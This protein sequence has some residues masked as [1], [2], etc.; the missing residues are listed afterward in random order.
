MRTL[1]LSLFAL[2]VVLP[3]QAQRSPLAIGAQIGSPT[4]LTVRFPARAAASWT[5]TL[6]FHKGGATL[7]LNRQYEYPFTESPL[8]YYVAPG[9]YLGSNG[10]DDLAVGAT[11][12][13]GVN[14]YQ[15]RFEVF[16]QLIPT[17]AVL[18]NTDFDV[19]AA[20]GVRFAL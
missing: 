11:L 18:P 9:G 6:A 8:H 16:L 17:L 1:A 4:A 10:D 5:G 19:G 15:D 12:P 20:V 2:A 14:F 13:L 7:G 3:A